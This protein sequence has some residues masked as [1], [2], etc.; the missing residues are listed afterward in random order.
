MA[1]YIDNIE[2]TTLEMFSHIQTSVKIDI[3]VG[4]FYF[5]GIKKILENEETRKNF[6]QENMK[7]RILVGLNI[8]RTM[9][10]IVETI[11]KNKKT[12][13]QI[14]E[15]SINQIID[16]LNSADF[17]DR[18]SLEAF[19][20]KLENGSLEIRKTKEP[21]HA[22]LYLFQCQ[23]D[24][25]KVGSMAMITGSSNLTSA[26]LAGQIEFNVVEENRDDCLIG[27]E[28]F[29]KLWDN[30]ISILDKNNVAL[31][32][33]KIGLLTHATPYEIFLKVITEYFA[34]T[35]T[36]DLEFAPSDAGFD[37]YSYQIHAIEKALEA[38]E[39]HNGVILADVVG[40]GKSVIASCI[41]KN[42]YENGSINRIF[43]ICPPPLVDSWESYNDS[44]ELNAAVYSLGKLKDVV[45]RVEKLNKN[46]K[47]LIIIDEA[48]RF[49][50]TKTRDYD[51]LKRICRNQKVLLLTATPL[52]NTSSDIFSLIELF[53]NIHSAS[54]RG[55]KS[56]ERMKTK[57]VEEEKKIRGS[58]NADDKKNLRKIA[59]DL[60]GLISPVL[61]RR[62]RK[63]L[64]YSNLYMEDLKNQNIE[65]N[66]VKEPQ[67]HD[68][69][70]NE[71]SNLYKDTFN[72]ITPNKNKDDKKSN[73]E[74]DEN[75][76][77]TESF[78]AIRYKAPMYITDRDVL[79]TIYPNLS[80]DSFVKEAST[81]LSN[82]MRRLLVRRFESS[83]VAFKKSIDNMIN[84][85][86]QIIANINT[87]NI[88]IISKKVQNIDIDSLLSS[89]DIDEEDNDDESPKHFIFDKK[90]IKQY[91]EKD[92]HIIENA[93]SVFKSD[94][95]N[96][97]QKDL[98]ILNGIKKKWQNVVTDYKLNKLIE[99]LGIWSKENSKRKIVIFSEFADTVEYLE[100][101]LNSNFRVIKYTS[102]STG[103]RRE[104]I[105]N[106][107]ASVKDTEQKDD[108]D[109]LI[110]TDTLSEG[111]NLHRAGI[112]VNYD[113]PYNPTKVI[114]RVG[115]INRIG[116]KVFD[117]IYIHNFVPS[118]ASKNDLNNVEIA[119]FKLDLINII[120]GND[121]KILTSD[122]EL[123]AI[124]KVYDN[125][126]LDTEEVSWDVEYINIYQKLK[127]N[128]LLDK[129]GNIIKYEKIK[130]LPPHLEVKRNSNFNGFIEITRYNKQIF[131]SINKNNDDEINIYSMEDVLKIIKADEEE[132]YIPTS[133][134]FYK[135]KSEWLENEKVKPIQKKSNHKTLLDLHNLGKDKT[136]TE[137]EFSYIKDVMSIGEHGH[138]LHASFKKIAAI[139]KENISAS[140]KVE[141][142]KTVIS[143]QYIQNLLEE[144][145]SG[146]KELN[147]ADLIVSEEFVC[148]DNIAIEQPKLF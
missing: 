84:R 92:I 103:K 12:Y 43:I 116:K 106:F 26:G 49:R 111:I 109:I 34:Y 35:N 124:F 48:H 113:I 58:N 17:N 72:T 132:K 30:S 91:Q 70:L 98:D 144:Y 133:D 76:K 53:Q 90:K 104:V 82:F 7:V 131:A 140:K 9:H 40:L 89:N 44:F 77:A 101:K 122:E 45:A 102:K 136:L 37:R 79:K 121:T 74:N 119:K 5:S 24:I 97:L 141:K 80:S 36:S 4:F 107:D 139:I 23:E 20:K 143:P 27:Q 93:K 29:N 46:N 57:I 148:T 69:E 100:E 8:D 60:V 50:N 55:Y 25:N 115:R 117:K 33:P 145:K 47:C 11:D 114:Q 52:N 130:N 137:G 66:N 75:K 39:M 134:D 138:I 51:Y 28:F 146:S 59:R 73:N 54:I 19:F 120:L 14:A 135:T 87:Y 118:A 125:N 95:F 13:N 1:K 127:N 64:Q 21:A 68:Y 86:T 42:M 16:F 99:K 128:E 112:V 22:K 85:Y 2:N 126:I 62:T 65:F 41:A 123:D 71:L 129:N 108:Y 81:N 61:I 110:T 96:L 83:L 31:I 15:D 32:V 10:S 78:E 18:K 94:F 67:I 3:L 38:I 63:D 142:I 147:N 56:I 6:L 88:F 105:A